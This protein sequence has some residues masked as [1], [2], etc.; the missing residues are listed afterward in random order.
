MDRRLLLLAFEPIVDVPANS[1]TGRELLADL[2]GWDSVA[3]LS[4]IALADEQFRVSLA[5]SDIQASRTVNDL[6]LL[7]SQRTNR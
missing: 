1:L 7:I 4:F 2:G 3:I 6:L 5:P